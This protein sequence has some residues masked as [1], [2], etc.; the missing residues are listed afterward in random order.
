MKAVETSTRVLQKISTTDNL[1]TRSLES[2]YGLDAKEPSEKIKSR[3]SE[4]ISNARCR[5]DPLSDQVATSTGIRYQRDQVDNDATNDI[6]CKNVGFTQ[7]A[8][9]DVVAPSDMDGW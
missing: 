4:T 7:V 8:G 5:F 2:Q 6:A 1:G 3:Y 9:A